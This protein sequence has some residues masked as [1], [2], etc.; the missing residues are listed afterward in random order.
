[1]STLYQICALLADLPQRHNSRKEAIKI[2]VGDPAITEPCES[3][4]KALRRIYRTIPSAFD[5]SDESCNDDDGYDV[6][7][8]KIPWRHP[9]LTTA[10]R[11]LDEYRRT[12]T[13]LMKATGARPMRRRHGDKL[14]DRKA[15]P[16]LPLPLYN[17][18]WYGS[19]TRH[20][21]LNLRAI[22]VAVDWPFGQ[23]M[24]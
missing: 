1:M 3:F 15:P 19:L 20:E 14:S 2:A 8:T 17:P 24:Q 12:E 22:D 4:W 13:K 10:I 11:V 16:G 6:E 5:S 21:K 7:S 23:L 9:E 18:Q